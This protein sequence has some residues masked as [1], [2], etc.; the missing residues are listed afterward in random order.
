MTKRAT[1]TPEAA[2]KSLIALD[3]QLCF[4]LYSASRAMTRAYQP[5]LQAMGITYPQYLVLMV[6]WEWCDSDI[7]TPSVS[8][9]GARLKLDSGTLTP[10]LKRMETR[11]LVERRRCAEDERKVLLSLTAAGESLEQQALAWVSGALEEGPVDREELDALR[12]KLRH[13]LL[14]IDDSHP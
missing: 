7:D 13:F 8:A 9:L 12:E 4:M 10:L 2:D 1:P 14:A 11:G 3:R 5:M 6:M